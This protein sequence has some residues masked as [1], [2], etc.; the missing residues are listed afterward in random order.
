[1]PQQIERMDPARTVLIIVDME[2]DFVKPGA[3]FEVPAGREMLPKLKE[4]I[5]FCR[6][7]GISVIYTTHAHRPDGTDAGRFADIYPA[8]AEGRGLVDGSDGIEV[9]A[10]IAPEPGEVIIKKHRYSAF[11]GTDLDMIL[12]GLGTDTVIVTGVTTENCCHA[13]AR[14]A[15]FRDYRV[16]FIS[17]CT[18]TLA[19]PDLG[20]G[21]L[22]ADELHRSTLIALAF[23]TAH[24]MTAAECIEKVREEANKAAAE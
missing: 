17:D 24:V 13:T 14:D 3:A 22:S 7:T 1:M 21:A 19:Y 15:M 8:I 23:S 6:G 20:Y 11:F 5:G 16:A 10:D 2:N 18:A 9:Y 12:R 4:L